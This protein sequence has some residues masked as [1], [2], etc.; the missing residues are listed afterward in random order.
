MSSAKLMDRFSCSQSS[1]LSSWLDM[2]RN[3]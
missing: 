2:V 3:P 1:W